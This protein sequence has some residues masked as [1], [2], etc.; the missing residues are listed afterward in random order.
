MELVRIK[1]NINLILKDFKEMKL[2]EDRMS[3]RLLYFL[4]QLSRGLF[5]AGIWSRKHKKHAQKLVQLQKTPF[6]HSF[7]QMT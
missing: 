3:L 1:K 6:I 5:Y 2:N 4:N 7:G